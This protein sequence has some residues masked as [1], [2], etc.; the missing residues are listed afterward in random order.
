MGKG[1]YEYSGKVEV[2]MFENYL[3]SS[4]EEAFFAELDVI[5]ELVEPLIEFVE[6]IINYDCLPTAVRQ[7]CTAESWH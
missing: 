3:A 5:L 4:K 1:R 6:E 7:N 2:T